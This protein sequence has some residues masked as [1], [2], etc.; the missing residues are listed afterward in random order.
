MKGFPCLWDLGLSLTRVWGF[1]GVSVP[2]E[3]RV[4]FTRVWGFEGV[5][6]PLGFRVTF[7]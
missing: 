6:V 5:S 2:L 7:N 1:E 4:K 3:F